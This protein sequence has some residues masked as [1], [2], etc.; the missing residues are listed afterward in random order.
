VRHGGGHSHDGQVSDEFVEQPWVGF[1]Y[2]F[3]FVC[4]APCDRRI[5]VPAELYDRLTCGKAELPRCKCGAKVDVPELSPALR[6][7]NDPALQDDVDHLIWYHTGTYRDWPDSEAYRTDVLAGI[8][9][10]AAPASVKRQELEQRMSLAV[11]VGTYESTIDNMM[12][13]IGEE[14]PVGSA[15]PQYF[16]HRVR[17]RLAPGDLAPGISDDLAD[18][19][20]RVP[21]NE[22]KKRNARAV[23]YVN[24]NEAH[25]S[26]S[27]AIDPAVVASVATIALPVESVAAETT[28]AAEA[29]AIAAAELASL[30]ADR[31]D[32]TGI[33]PLLQQ[34]PSAVRNRYPDPSD[35]ERARITQVLERCTKWGRQQAAVWDSFVAVLEA[36]YLP[37]VN[38]HIRDR[39]EGTLPPR[40]GDPADYHRQFRL[41]AALLNHPQSVIAQ[42]AKAP[43]RT[44]SKTGEV[45]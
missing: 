37:A 26:I 32:T 45:S 39:F 20:G 4:P 38:P 42:L 2:D 29:T 22:L 33:D 28:A 24:A 15:A 17:L 1:D 40:D 27:M 44:F 25:G 12:R 41:R 6:D 34:F 8:A 21:L 11:H 10:L 31:P 5:V 7:V 23:R 9:Q 18:W 16:L 14:D 13:R 3:T 43:V 35:P 36:E 19:V 30:D